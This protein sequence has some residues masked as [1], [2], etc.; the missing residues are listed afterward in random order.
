MTEKGMVQMSAPIF[1]GFEDMDRVADARDE[2]F[3]LEVVVPVDLHDVLHELDPVLA[4]VVETTDERAHVRRPDLG[5]EQRLV[6]GEDEGHVDPRTSEA[7]VF[8]A[9]RPAG[10]MGHFT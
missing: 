9:W 2:H 4:L 7:S 8:V 1:R 5:G 6:R 3:G 10:V